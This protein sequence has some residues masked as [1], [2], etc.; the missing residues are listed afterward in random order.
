MPGVGRPQALINRDVEA[1][2]FFIG[3]LHKRWG[4]LS[5]EYSSGFEEEFRLAQLLEKRSDVKQIWLAFKAIEPDF[6]NDPGNQLQK[7]LEFRKE[8]IERRDI[9]FKEFSDSENWRR[10]VSGWLLDFVLSQSN[11]SSQTQFPESPSHKSG[12][13]A[14]QSSFSETKPN[15]LSFLSIL[16]I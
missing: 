3:V 5:G 1:C 11:L 10:Q 7:V 14:V 13:A 8:R 16:S 2:D 15:N 4:S 12:E 9:L 6:L